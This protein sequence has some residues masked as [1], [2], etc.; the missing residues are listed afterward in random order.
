MTYYTQT[1]VAKLIGVSQ[2][3]ISRYTK[4]DKVTGKAQLA[5]IRLGK[6]VLIS[7]EDL[8]AFLAA[9]RVASTYS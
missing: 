4:P 8:Q 1:E 7:D 9:K 3:M 2:C 5:H 6:R